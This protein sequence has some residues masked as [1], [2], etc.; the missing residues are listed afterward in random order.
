[1]RRGPILHLAS[2]SRGGGAVHMQTLTATLVRLGHPVAAVMP[3]DGGNVEA[4][5]FSRSGVRFLPLL[6]PPGALLRTVSGL[7]RILG[8][9][10][11]F[12]VHAHGSRAAFWAYWAL[13]WARLRRTLLVLSVHGFATPFCRTPRRLLQAAAERRVARRA[14]A[15]IAVS[16]AEREALLRAR[17]APPDKVLLVRY[18]FDLDPFTGLSGAD[19]SRAR[20]LLGV[21]PE[22][23]L[24]LAVC[25]LGRPRDFSTL[26]RAFRGVA[27]ALPGAR[28]FLVGDGPLRAEVQALVR[29]LRLEEA[30]TLWGFRRDVARFYAA[31]DYFVLTG[32]GWE[33]LPLSV[34]E[35]QASGLPVA[36]T[37]AGGAREA[38]DPGNTGLLV[39]CRAAGAL[40]EALLRLAADP[41]LRSAMGSEGRRFATARFQPEPMAKRIES[42]YASL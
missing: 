16:E 19:R 17:I 20:E 14:S 15:V 10:S 23:S 30:V 37:D 9:E 7:A 29:E 32:W 25:R 18:G 38:F 35:A 40:R 31:A 41:V 11:P 6:P 28:L 22:A 3:L 39:P 5:D 8:S 2:S 36:V 21:P 24:G 1:M 33:G 34:I 12:L 13:K 42:I 4:D 26:L 27:D